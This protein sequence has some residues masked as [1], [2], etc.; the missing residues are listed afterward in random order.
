VTNVGTR[1]TFN[2]SGITV[3]THILDFN[4]EIRSGRIEVVFERR[5][6]AE[7]KFSGADELRAQIQRDIESA[8]RYF[9][10]RK[11]SV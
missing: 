1:P 3:E 6:R 5:L 11:S 10:V 8:R 2:G 9:T 7:Q 4:Q